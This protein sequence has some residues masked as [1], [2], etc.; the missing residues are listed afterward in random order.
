MNRLVA[1]LFFFSGACGL[2]YEVVWT[3]MMT[4]VFGSTA[5]AIGTVLAAYMS[6]L[7]AGSWLLGRVADRAKHPLRLYAYLEVGVALA[8]ATAHLLLTQVTPAYLA[9]YEVFG[10]SHA[11][12]AVARFIMAFVIIVAPTTLMGATLPVL[13]RFVV[14]GSSALGSGLSTLYSINTVG[15]VVGAFIAG[16]WLIGAFGVHGAVGVAI[17]GNIAVGVVAWVAA[18]RRDPATAVPPAA[19]WQST[20]DHERPLQPVNPTTYRL[21]LAGL[22]VSGLTSFS[23]EV[24]WSRC[25]HF[26]TGNSTYAVTTV[27]VAFLSGIALGG[28]LIRVPM[29]RGLDAAATFGW[30]QV[31]IAVSAAVAMPIL[32]TAF[33]PES[34]RRHTWGTFGSFWQLAFARF[35][36]ATLVMLVPAVLFGATFPLAGYI[37]VKRV[38]KAGASIGRVYA[39]NTLGNV[40]GALLPGL[41]LIH[42][43]G[44]QRGLLIMAALNLVV[45]FGV[46]LSR[47]A[48]VRPLRW[49]TPA[50]FAIVVLAA[51]NFP[52]AFRLPLAAGGDWYR[53]LYLRDGPSATT[54]VLMNPDTREMS[55]TVDGVTIGGTGETDY[56]QQLLAHLPK[57]LLE[58]VSSELS[59]GLGSGILA[60]ESA[61]HARVERIVCVEIEPT[62]I[63]G[64]A[65]FAGEE[66]QR[67]G[68]SK[69][70]PV[71]DD[72]ANFLRT[73]PHSYDVVSADEKTAHEYASNGFSYSRDYYELIRRRLKPG[74]LVVQWVPTDLPHRQYRMILKTFSETFP[75]VGIWYFGPALM[76]GTSNT[77]LVGS[78]AR[79][80]P[81]LGRARRW[82]VSDSAAFGG[83]ARYGLGTPEA[84]FAQ[85]WTNRGVLY[86]M[87]AGDWENTLAHPRYEFYSPGDYTHSSRQRLAENL[88]FLMRLRGLTPEA[89]LPGLAPGSGQDSLMRALRGAESEYLI[90]CGK[91][92]HGAPPQVVMRHLDRAVELAPWNQNLRARVFAQYWELG[93]RYFAEGNAAATAELFRRGLEAYDGHAMGH[94]EYAL[95]LERIGEPGQAIESARRGLAL[96]PNLLAARRVLA[97]LLLS[98]RP[99][100]GSSRASVRHPRRRAGRRCR[101][102]LTWRVGKGKPPRAQP[103]GAIRRTPRGGSGLTGARRF[104]PVHPC[105]CLVSGVRS[106]P[107]LGTQG[108]IGASH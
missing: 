104:L 32:F 56:K 47:L 34:I 31:L 88:D 100:E 49:A 27:L 77:V 76:S 2:V 13:V 15:A 95:A 94:V 53:V 65:W 44:V 61:R 58:D 7:A 17:V 16:F 4:H 73:T 79:I 82:M 92:L 9:I 105:G 85:F 102:S 87:V 62:V 81:D 60:R 20:E 25:L 12:L 5:L 41:V 45:G 39:I 96:D 80:E 33:D 84:I 24:Y 18:A 70:R 98:F 10:K 30:I 51:F 69:I 29:R 101:Q 14:R 63:E 19:A 43:L 68:G 83:L 46:L 52:F 48:D 21:I 64:S 42:W 38:E 23:Y 59:V 35:G 72:V 22:F 54:A 93:G 97:E 71:L 37:G 89:E 3:R 55:M 74:G 103:E 78:I 107:A 11:A 26:V 108:R 8:A 86:P 36:L 99:A 1:I 50:A 40:L 67:R 6:G 91:S 57:L 90:A 106:D 28:Y 66:H 75:H